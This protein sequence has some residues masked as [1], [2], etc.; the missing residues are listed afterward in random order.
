MKGREEYLYDGVV[1]YG[2]D[3]RKGEAWAIEADPSF[4]Y[5]SFEAVTGNLD[6]IRKRFSES[7]VLVAKRIAEQTH[8][9]AK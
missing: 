1:N 5:A 7:A 6:E 9:A 8:A 4:A 3:A 2:V